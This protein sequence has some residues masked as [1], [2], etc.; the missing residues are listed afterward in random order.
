M[1]CRIVNVNP[2]NERRRGTV[3][4]KNCLTTQVS[5]GRATENPTFENPL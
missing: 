5:Y 2:P 3:S 1:I 4:S